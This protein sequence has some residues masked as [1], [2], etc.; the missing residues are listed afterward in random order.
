MPA[1]EG[2]ALCVIV[3]VCVKHSSS[4]WVC[5]VPSP[6]KGIECVSVSVNLP[7]PETV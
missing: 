1:V 2:Q 7:S 4:N 3:N 6:G 5:C